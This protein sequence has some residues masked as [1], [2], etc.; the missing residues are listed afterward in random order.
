MGHLFKHLAVRLWTTL[1]IGSLATLVALPPVAGSLGP[2]WM[3]VPCLGVFA[4][5]FWLSGL[6]FATLGRRRLTRLLK[7]AA[8]WDRAGMTREAGQALARAAGILEE[9]EG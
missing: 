9:K 8:V 4:V 7:E 6:I 3:L 2:G 1:A 5:V